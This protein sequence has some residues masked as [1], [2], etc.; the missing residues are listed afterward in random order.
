MSEIRYDNSTYWKDIHKEY[1]GTL[2]AVGWP[3]LCEEFN[4]LK[5]WSEAEAFASILDGIQ[6]KAG[7]SI[8][9]VG[10]GIGF[11]TSL[12][13]RIFGSRG[14]AARV[15]VLDISREA[16]DQV[17]SKF[18]AVSTV[19][20]DLKTVPLD[21]FAGQFNLVTAIMVLLHLTDIESYFRALKFC[22]RSVGDDGYLLLY[23]PLIFRNFT[24]YGSQ[25]FDSFGDNSTPRPLII[26]DNVMHNEGF[27][28]VTLRPGASW[29]LNSPIQSD[30]AMGF[31]MR[32]FVWNS[33][34]RLVY[35][36]DR[37]TR[38]LSRT[39][40]AADKH[41]KAGGGYSGSFVL[42]RRLGALG[43]SSEP[44]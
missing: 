29:L 4:R 22:A 28:R 12:K 30:S 37:Q 17:K 19:E 2:R 5:Y 21:R 14:R 27:S 1:A 41:L 34:I 26:I 38:M 36:S 33:L 13:Q 8:L 7:V 40:L 44:K 42:Y 15:T 6:P 10:V 9:E 35:R 20:A 11:W 24:P 23:E 31:S 16:L 32:S 18:P 43:A 39:L 3:T 25:A